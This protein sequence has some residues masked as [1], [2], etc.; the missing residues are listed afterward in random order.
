MDTRIDFKPFQNVKQYDH[1]IVSC[2]NSSIIIDLKNATIKQNN[3]SFYVEW[4][5]LYVGVSFINFEI[6]QII[7]VNPINNQ[8]YIELSSL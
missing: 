8:L 5:A 1:L 2:H 3:H 6:E 7:A 4:L